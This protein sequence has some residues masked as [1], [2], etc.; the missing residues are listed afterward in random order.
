MPHW[1]A[2]AGVEVKGAIVEQAAVAMANATIR[3]FPE[4]TLSL[5]VAFSRRKGLQ[6]NGFPPWR[7][8][9]YWPAKCGTNATRAVPF[10]GDG[11][12]GA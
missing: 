3:N 12:C 2:E 9:A 10:S 1:L 4:C 11:K 5:S 6:R 8:T 7:P